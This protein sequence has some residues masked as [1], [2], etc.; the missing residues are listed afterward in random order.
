VKPARLLIIYIYSIVMLFSSVYR[1]VWS[2]RCLVPARLRLSGHE[3][4]SIFYWGLLAIIIAWIITRLSLFWSHGYQVEAYGFLRLSSV[5]AA[6]LHLPFTLILF[7]LKWNSCSCDSS[8]SIYEVF[9]SVFFASS[10]DHHVMYLLLHVL[11][12]VLKLPIGEF[13]NRLIFTFD[14]ILGSSLEKGGHIWWLGRGPDLA[15]KG[16]LAGLDLV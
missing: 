4:M 8:C 13:D 10:V 14:K 2:N 3:E 11:V 7:W 15:L 6:W 16:R 1:W 5:H 9:M 12:E